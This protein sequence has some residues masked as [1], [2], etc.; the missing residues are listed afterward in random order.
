MQVIRLFEEGL[1]VRLVGVATVLFLKSHSFLPGPSGVVNPGPSG[2]VKPKSHY[3]AG[4]KL[5]LTSD[6][7][8]AVW[9][10]EGEPIRPQAIPLR[11][12]AT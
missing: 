11:R 4:E 8:S 3:A 10:K 1:I 12:I 2:V 9:G 6:D 5:C 7:K